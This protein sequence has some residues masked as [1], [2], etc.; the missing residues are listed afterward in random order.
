MIADSVRVLSIALVPLY[1]AKTSLSANV[2]GAAPALLSG[3]S[4]N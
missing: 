4:G 1:L 2:L 3:F